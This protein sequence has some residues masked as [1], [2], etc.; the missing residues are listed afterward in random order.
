MDPVTPTGAIA[1]APHGA[2]AN[3]AHPASERIQVRSVPVRASL[4][5]L[6]LILSL[7]GCRREA[8]PAP[9]APAPLARVGDTVIAAED[10][11]AEAHRL[12]AAGQ[13]V[14]DAASVLD[15]LI[16]REAMLQEAST[17]TWANAHEA[18][19][20]RE[21]LLLSQ[22]LEHTM[23]AEKGKVTISDDELRV[24]YEANA[25]EFTRP[26][27]ARL[28]ILHRKPATQGA[29]SS[30]E[31]LTAALRQARQ[32]YLD[33]PAQ[34]TRS[35][36]IPG[37]GAIAAE[38]SEHA[39]SRY[40]GGD[41]GWIEPGRDAYPLPTEIVEAGFAL[42]AGGVSDVLA[43]ESG[44]YIVMKQDQRDARSAPFEEVAAT[45]RRRLLRARRD[46]VES[47]FKSNVLMRADV[48][49]DEIQAATLSLPET[50]SRIPAPPALIPV[51]RLNPATETPD[52]ASTVEP[53][54]EETE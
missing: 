39:T 52:A 26:A 18:R 51:A 45:L 46:A 25:A 30:A 44:L 19:R 34:A 41:V 17:S 7:A 28:A 38:A 29:D 48:E 36:R 43:A 21:N 35:G 54:K 8:P 6:V 11:A 40:R 10:V 37:F 12:R 3:S 24:F 27:M 47:T 15:A 14:A 1:P 32:A 49:I 2:T 53:G 22:W 9:P 31:A 13:P 42:P 4:T 33:D 20:E 23:Q 50:T 5:A 16:L